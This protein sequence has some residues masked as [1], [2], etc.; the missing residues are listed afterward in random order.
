MRAHASSSSRVIFGT[1]IQEI[2]ATK[3]G[4][5][6]KIIFDDMLLFINLCDHVSNEAEIGIEM[7][8]QTMT[9]YLHLSLLKF[10]SIIFRGY[11]ADAIV[12]GVRVKFVPL[13]L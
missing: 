6:V 1:R 12:Q 7:H 11:W 2:G 5:F 3:K 8:R 9:D 4:T 13:Q 10:V